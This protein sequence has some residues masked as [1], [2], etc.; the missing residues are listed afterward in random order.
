MGV[1]C[2][3]SASEAA[4]LR[5][6]T[7]VGARAGHRRHHDAVGQRQRAQAVGGE[8]HGGILL[9]GIAGKD[10]D[11]ALRATGASA[12]SVGPAKMVTRRSPMAQ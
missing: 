10:G 3:N 8:Q 5:A 9:R 11:G 4:A 7:A 2:C 1:N 6:K 12:R